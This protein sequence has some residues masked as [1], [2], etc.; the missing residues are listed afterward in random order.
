MNVY[1]S[2]SNRGSVRFRLLFLCAL[3][4]AVGAAVWLVGQELRTSRLQARFFSSLARKLTYWVEPGPSPS[5]RFPAPGGPYDERMGYSLLPSITEKLTAKGFEIRAQARFSPELL[6]YVDRGLFAAYHEKEQAGLEVLDR[7]G[8]VLVKSSYPER[9]FRSFEAIPEPVVQTL[10]FIENRELLDP[11]EPRRNPAVEWDRLFRSLLEAAQQP[12]REREQRLP[13]A[14]TLATQI[15]KFRHSPRGLTSSIPEKGRQMVSA[16]VRSYLDGEET[17]QTRRKIVLDYL[18]SVPLAAIPGY[19]EVCGLGD[20]L[21]AWYG[22]ELDAILPLLHLDRSSS[23]AAWDPEQAQIFKETLSL[24]LAQRRPSFYLLEDPQALD[25][26]ANTYLKLLEQGGV[27]PHG[28]AQAAQGRPLTLRRSAPERPKEAFFERKAANAVRTRL[29][30]LLEFERLYDLDRLDLVVKSTLD[31]ATQEQVTRFLRDLQA[32]DKARA[33]GLFGTHLLDPAHFGDVVYSFT[34]YERTRRGNVLRVQT[35][36]LDQP[37]DINQGV[38]LELGSSAKLRTLVTYLEVVAALHEQYAPLSRQELAA[39]DVPPGDRLSRW[40]LDY[41]ASAQDR[42]LP[43]M[44]EAAMERRYSADPGESFF[45]GGGLHTFSNFNEE[46]DFK[47][48][49]VREAFR[50]SINLAFIRLMRDVVRYY[51]Y[52]VPGST[53]LL[54]KDSHDPVRQAYLARFADQEGRVFLKRFYGKYKGKSAD[55]MLENL[56][57]GIQPTPKRL[58]VI[59]RAARPEAGPESFVEFVRTV[60]P[61]TALGPSD[62]QQIY[63]QNEAAQWSLSDRGYI[64]HVHPLE[65][66]TVEYLRAHPEAT[67]E[68]VLEASSEARQEVYRWLFK[69]R[70]DSARENRI[71]QIVELEAFQEIHRCWKRL[72]YPFNSLVPSYATAIGSSAD[73]PAA[74]AEL[75]GIILNGGARYPLVNIE[76][77]CFAAGTPYETHFALREGGGEQV[78][79]PEIA[80]VVRRALLE[81]VEKGTAVRLAQSPFVLANGTRLAVGGKTGTG[82]NRYDVFGPG[83]TLLE[84]RVVNRTATFAFM[85]GDR[86]FGV[87]TAYVPRPQ[88][89]NYSFTSSLPV[90]VLKAMAPV[91]M[92]LLERA[93]SEQPASSRVQEEPGSAS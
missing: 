38:K 77:L 64:A 49:S 5:I 74:L 54:V 56:V 84:S 79:R 37:F 72:G 1:G 28:F 2:C 76:E 91:L 34:L 10:L 60:L 70:Y 22:R 3:L 39:A 92:P 62:L 83:G 32:L 23:G 31:R 20:G 26:L 12:F 86:F 14:S 69:T 46:D 89:A 78:L 9:V 18:N 35:D 82:D 25:G 68:E 67:L 55:E 16:S 15:E 66:W 19:G 30:S 93:G 61:E 50:N 58:A 65:L 13:G 40:A 57:Q 45:T 71:R 51:M 53:A 90:Q 59:F 52:R 88:A 11:R 73:R 43:A 8:Q 75:V 36:N 63:F 87:I 48:P 21:W 41:L 85:I 4:L 81:V 6:R 24:L 29:A 33:A 80:A 27:L 17:W 42:S 47:I 7:D 44:L